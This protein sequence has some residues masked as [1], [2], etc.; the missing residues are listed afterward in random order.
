VASSSGE[1]ALLQGLRGSFWPRGVTSGKRCCWWISTVTALKRCAASGLF[2][3]TGGLTPIR[4]LPADSWIDPFKKAVET[5][6]AVEVT[7]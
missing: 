7:E 3:G 5:H 2:C 1:A 6:M 4:G